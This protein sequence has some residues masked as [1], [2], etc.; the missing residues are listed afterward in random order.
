MAIEHSFRWFLCPFDISG[1]CLIDWTLSYFWPLQDVLGSSCIFSASSLELAIS[2]GH[3][4]S[5]YWRVALETKLWVLSVL[6]A[7]EMS[8]FV[9][10]RSSR[11][12]EQGDRVYWPVRIHT[13]MKIS[14]CVYVK[15][16]MSL[17]AC[18]KLWAM[19]TWIIPD[20]SP[21]VYNFFTPVLRKLSLTICHLVTIFWYILNLI[22]DVQ[23]GELKHLWDHNPDPETWSFMVFQKV[24]QAHSRVFS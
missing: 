1:V 23:L 17:Y 12:T 22:I 4:G 6:V 7:M 24:P 9:F 18:L 14:L 10:F 21:L 16:N 19:T 3:S 11:P 13:S 8:F 15:L 20:F 5:F 2:P